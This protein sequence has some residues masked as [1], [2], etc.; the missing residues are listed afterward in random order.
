MV[1]DSLVVEPERLTLDVLKVGK[2]AHVHP[3]G[4]FLWT[5]VNSEV[6]ADARLEFARDVLARGVDA[7]GRFRS[8]RDLLL[9]VAGR[10]VG[11]PCPGA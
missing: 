9:R 11:S 7:D 5:W 8:A 3:R 2:W 10:G 1:G 6:V 4:A